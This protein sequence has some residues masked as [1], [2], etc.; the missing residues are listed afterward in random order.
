MLARETAKEVEDREDHDVSEGDIAQDLVKL[1]EESAARETFALIIDD[2]WHDFTLKPIL[3]K[4]LQAKQ[5]ADGQ[6]R[7]I[8][9]LS[10]YFVGTIVQSVKG[11]TLP[12]RTTVGDT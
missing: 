5:L 7:V 6:L 8:F 11:T 3:E 1:G 10:S 4:Q 9:F 12:L 2:K